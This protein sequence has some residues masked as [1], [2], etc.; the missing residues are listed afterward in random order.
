M[1]R[2]RSRS[3][4]LRG[5]AQSDLF[6]SPRGITDPPSW[7]MLPEETRRAVASLMARLILDHGRQDHG[8]DRRGAADDI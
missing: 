8:L 6:G 5:P 7:G 2:R 3:S 4:G 1:R